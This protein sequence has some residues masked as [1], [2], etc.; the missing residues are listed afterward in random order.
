LYI[1]LSCA[2][3]AAEATSNYLEGKGALEA[4]AWAV[5]EKF[6]DEFRWGDLAFSIYS[7]LGDRVLEW[8]VRGIKVTSTN[9]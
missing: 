5:E 9:W 1:G 8:L 3:L 2:K 4:Y 7:G 6:G